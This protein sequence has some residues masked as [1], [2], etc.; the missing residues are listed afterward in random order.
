VPA[1]TGWVIPLE[2]IVDA[3]PAL[4]A[5]VDREQR[6]GFVNRAYEEWYGRPR[7]EIPGQ[8]VRQFLGEERY[9]KIRPYVTRALAGE[10]LTFETATTH[11]D[12]TLRSV[13]AVYVPDTAPDG[14]VRGYISLVSDIT[15]LQRARAD[16]EAANLT[17]DEFLATL[18]HELRTPLNA[19]VGWV[20]L[21][22]EGGLTPEEQTRA[23][24]VIERNARLQVQ[25]IED[26]ID[27]SRI[28]AGKGQLEL[29]PVHPVTIID[30]V[31]DSMRP[32]ATAKGVHLDTK[33]DLRAGPIA[34]DAERL[35]QVLWNVIAN[36]IKFTARDG[37]VDITL[38]RNASTVTLEVRDTGEGISPEM[39]PHI[40]ERFRQGEGGTKRRHGGL[41]IGLA[42]VKHLVEAHGGT[43]RAESPGRGG[44]TVITV[45]LP[46]I[47]Y[48]DTGGTSRSSRP[49]LRPMMVV[50]TDALH[51]CRVLVVDDDPDALD[52]FARLLQRAGAEVR[53]AASARDALDAMH[54]AAF[55]VVLSDIE[56]PDEDGMA[57]LQRVRE[58]GSRLPVVAVTAYG[59]P[60]DRARMLAAGFAAH[61][62]KPVDAGELVTVVQRLVR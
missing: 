13:R 15:D 28:V 46:L 18:S 58:E 19:V 22:G 43:V 14:T 3:V 36:A 21:L 51:R 37:R 40:F 2:L 23:F 1:Y 10:A 52:L 4:I 8:T 49:P 54:A 16:A 29:R 59:S 30:A 9:E 17:K 24:E 33:I 53:T 55:D 60:D 45:T 39:L 35:Q 20:R 44:G 31:V 26:L 25:L 41:G 7:G 27:I 56:M 47:A 50:P 32:A 38:A 12:G 57:F 11:R 61:V 42:L 62:A 5:Y 6:Y 34:G 48:A